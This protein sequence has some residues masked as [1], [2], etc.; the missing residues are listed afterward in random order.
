MILVGLCGGSGS[1]KGTFCSLMLE[2]GVPSIDTDA[3][4]REMTSA[5]SDCLDE[6]VCEFGSDILNPDGSL[7]RRRLACIV[8]A[9]EDADKKR[10]RL[11]KITHKFILSETRRILDSFRADGY[12]AAIIDA[13][14]LFESG[15]DRECDLTVCVIADR[16]TRIERIMKRDNISLSDAERRIDAQLSNSELIEKCDYAISNDTDLCALSSEID[17]FVDYLF[18]K[19]YER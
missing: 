4:Y 2:R 12:R 7:D 5:K 17:R 15:F 14:V 1:G 19:H 9:G 11:N 16:Q 3:L 10:N 6:L 18:K 8:F 13:P